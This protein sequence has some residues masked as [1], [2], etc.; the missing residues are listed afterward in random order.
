[1][2]VE[3]SRVCPGHTDRPTAPGKK[4]CQG[5]LDRI[6]ARAILNNIKGMCQNHPKVP[7]AVGRKQCE[8]CLSRKKA[9]LAVNREKLRLHEKDRKT[10]D[11]KFKLACNL[12]TRFYM[13]I[14]A[15]VSGTATRR[16]TS[17]VRHLGCS[18]E[19]LKLYLEARFKPGM[20]WENHGTHSW[21]I[22]HIRPLCSFDLT[23]VA[24]Q[25]LACHYTNLQP[26]WAA[27]NLA[28]HGKWEII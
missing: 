13:A 11:P 25:R 6:K 15:C 21:H 9:Y 28:K 18:L 26:L 4:V 3:A 20:T 12:R 2:E 23:D 24:Q 7:V 1:M 10:R 17:S 22:D 16:V 5:C 8:A 19:E 27:E 14:R